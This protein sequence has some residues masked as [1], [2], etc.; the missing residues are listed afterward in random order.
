MEKQKI[1]TRQKY[2]STKIANKNSKQQQ[3]QQQQVKEV[4]NNIVNTMKHIMSVNSYYNLS[5]SV[6]LFIYQE[7]QKININ[8][9][10]SKHLHNRH[11]LIL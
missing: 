1:G 5:S 6:E 8:L 4:T 9:S 10:T 7:Y 2:K 11:T 3:Q